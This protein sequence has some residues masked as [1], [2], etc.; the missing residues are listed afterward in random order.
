MLDASV[1][2][3]ANLCVVGNIN[4][5]IKTSPF[6]AGEYLFS[7]GETSIEGI[8]E[9]IG[10]G[11]ANC[12]AIAARLGARSTFLGQIGDDDTGSRLEIAMTRAGVRCHLHKAASLATGT[13]VNLVYDTGQRHFLSRH[14][15]NAALAFEHLDLAPLAGAGHLLRADIWFSEAMLFGGNGKLFAAAR[16][17]GVPVSI[18]LNWD[19][20]WGR[21]DRDEIVRRKEAVRQLLPLV[22]LAHGN[23]RELNEF[24]GEKELP[25]SLAKLLAWGAKAVVVHLGAQGAGY[26]DAAGLVVEPPA[27]LQGQVMVTGSGDVLSTCMML[28]HQLDG[29][30]VGERLRLANRITAGFMEGALKLLPSL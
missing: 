9:T 29:A 6:R 3:G 5:D 25:R 16:E 18:D 19:P 12:A 20:K 11:G 23:A 10:G 22:D 28:L 24:A 4:R 8:H 17:A 7:D 27:P 26:F 30:S 15:N 13:T 2:R 1:F 21:A 14:P